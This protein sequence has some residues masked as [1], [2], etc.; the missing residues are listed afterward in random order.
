MPVEY[1]NAI[2]MKFR[3]IPPGEFQLGC[4]EQEASDAEQ[5]MK[6]SGVGEVWASFIARS[7][8]PRRPVRLTKGYYM[9]VHEVTVG[10]FRTFVQETDHVSSALGNDRVWMKKAANA[11]MSNINWHDAQAFCKWLSA[12]D[13]R[14]FQVPTEA[15]WEFACRSGAE[16]HW[17]WG[18]DAAVTSEYAW[19][20]RERTEGPSIVGGRKAN[21]FGLFDMHVIYTS[22]VSIALSPC[23]Q[24]LISSVDNP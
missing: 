7:S 4:T 23:D 9:G 19:M 8:Q 13:K 22:G 18:D 15:Q 20:Q 3:L 21:P 1:T 24:F 12:K 17:S 2:G 14:V 5:A 6:N 16:G 11:P 10:Q